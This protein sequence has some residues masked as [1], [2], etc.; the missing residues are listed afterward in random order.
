MSFRNNFKDIASKLIH[1]AGEDCTYRIINK[2]VYDQETLTVSNTYTNV[3]LKAYRKVNSLF[4]AENPAYV[5]RIIRTIQIA[6]NDLSQAPNQGDK[7]VFGDETVT[8]DRIQSFNAKDGPAVW[9]LI[10]VKD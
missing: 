6:A 1:G 5:G 4:V 10:C 3:S 7:L 2:G 8:V 9:T